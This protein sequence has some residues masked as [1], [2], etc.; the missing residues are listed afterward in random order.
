[1]PRYAEAIPSP[2]G[3]I[4]GSL[5]ERAEGGRWVLPARI[6]QRERGQSEGPVLENAYQSTGCNIITHIRFHDVSEPN[7][8]LSRY[9]D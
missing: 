3:K 7:P 6:I 1:M 8:I 4:A 5:N 2:I 9:L